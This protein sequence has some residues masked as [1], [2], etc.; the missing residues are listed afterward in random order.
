MNKPKK[1]DMTGWGG[2]PLDQLEKSLKAMGDVPVQRL[3]KGSL[4]Y[5]GHIWRDD[6]TGG[7]EFVDGMAAFRVSRSTRYRENYDKIDWGKK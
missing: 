2:A 1:I 7:V 5:D 3:N 6:G 4:R